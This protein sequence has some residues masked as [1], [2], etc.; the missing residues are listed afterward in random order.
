MRAQGTNLNPQG[1]IEQMGK[2]VNQ[3]SIYA[4][5]VRDD[6]E[7]FLFLSICRGSEGDIYVNFP[8]D[9][10]PDWKPHSSF[11]ASGQ[12]HQKSFGHK[13]MVRQEQKPDET[14]WGSKNVV[15]TGIAADEPRAINTSYQATDFQGVFEI[16]IS[17]LRKEK[18]RTMISVDITDTS[19]KPIIT[20]GARILRQTI[21][22]DAI[23]WIVVTLFDTYSH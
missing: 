14:F 4:V 18:Y 6:K 13:Y 20:P 23:P 12:H 7:L 9:Y 17:E 21:F 1:E 15:S 2:Q 5:A 3:K 11:H 16:P 10:E 8:R 19:G 22:K